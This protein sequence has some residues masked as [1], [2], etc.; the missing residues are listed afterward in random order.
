[1]SYAALEKTFYV[2]LLC[3]LATLVSCLGIL[4]FNVVTADHNIVGYEL[5]DGNLSGKEEYW[6][7]A[8]IRNYWNDDNIYFSR[9]DFTIEQIRD[10]INKLN[11]LVENNV[12]E[13]KEMKN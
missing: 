2:V 9:K 12:V 3:A 11:A 5:V 7:V 4:L 1:M 13:E 6:V 8:G 10:E